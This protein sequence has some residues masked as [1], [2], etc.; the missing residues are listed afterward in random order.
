MGILFAA[1]AAIALLAFSR[2]RTAVPGGADGTPP[3]GS[4]GGAGGGGTPGGT[5]PPTKTTKSYTIESG[6]T[7]NSVA[8]AFSTTPS[9]L[10]ELNPGLNWKVFHLGGA[11]GARESFTQPLHPKPFTLTQRVNTEE[12]PVYHTEAGGTGYAKDG[13][14]FYF[15]A[16]YDA[17]GITTDT[18][19]GRIYSE[20]GT[21]NKYVLGWKNGIVIQV[22]TSPDA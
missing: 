12:W 4:G 14:Y 18:R 16:G 3:P 11:G 7:P 22:P 20:G 2:R 15:P 10:A 1:V 9:K 21:W 5:K 13:G 6:D 8:N 17:P 19:F